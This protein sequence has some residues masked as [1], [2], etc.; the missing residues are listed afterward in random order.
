MRNVFSHEKMGRLNLLQID[1]SRKLGD[2][3]RMSSPT[4]K[5]SATY[6]EAWPRKYEEKRTPLQPHHCAARVG[7]MAGLRRQTRDLPPLCGLEGRAHHGLRLPGGRRHQRRRGAIAFPIFTKL[8][9]IAPRD[10]RNFS[11]AIQ[12]VGMGAASLS[13]LYLRIPI[14]RR[15]LLFAGVPGILEWFSARTSSRHSFHRY[16]CARRLPCL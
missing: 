6:G 16:S 8:L 9:H 15:A 14:E 4:P 11:L 13:I 12:S 3:P 2:Q 1:D 5:P 7:A 10:A